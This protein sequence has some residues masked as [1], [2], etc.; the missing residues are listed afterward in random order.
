MSNN[1]QLSIS[2]KPPGFRIDFLHKK[3]P[4][5][6]NRNSAFFKK[7]ISGEE[8]DFIR[9]PIINYYIENNVV[10]YQEY[11]SFVDEEHSQI[12]LSELIINNNQIT[13]RCKYFFGTDS[14][15]RDFLSRIILGSR[16]SL[17]VGII[18]VLISLLIGL[19]LGLIS[20]Y[21]GG[22][23]DLL[24]QWLINVIWSIPTLLLVISISIALGTGFWQIFIAIGL[25]MWVEVARVTRG[26]V[27]RLRELSYIKAVKSIG[28]SDFR[29]IIN[30]ILPNILNPII[31][32]STAN[33]ATAILLES[34]LSFLGLG[35]Q[36]PTPSWGMMIKNHY[37]YI[38]IDE[39]YLAILPGLCIVLLVL[40]FMSLGN[41]FRD[42]KDVKLK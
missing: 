5:S 6:V 8:N 25:T 35:I 22:K 39:P 26:E 20:G 38:L 12:D 24:I 1:Q 11:G 16:V 42:L 37:L 34:G 10:Y 40:S 4:F 41:V 28:F 32:I 18:S 21:Y 14:K 29:I 13:H 27:L 3:K 9:I 33:F 36:P 19:T 23:I 31:V 7:F 17:S 30:H 15:G 2:N